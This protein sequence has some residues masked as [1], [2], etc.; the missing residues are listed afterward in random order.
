HLLRGDAL[1]Q[2]ERW[3]A[4]RAPHLHLAASTERFLKASRALKDTA[5]LHARRTIL[6]APCY[7]VAI[8]LILQLL[9]LIPSVSRFRLTHL[10]NSADLA[11]IAS[12]AIL[13]NQSGRIDPELEQELLRHAGAETVVIRRNDAQ[14]IVLSGTL[15]SPVSAT[16]DLRDPSAITLIADALSVLLRREE[17]LIRV[18]ASPQLEG[19]VITEL[20]VR[21]S[22]L[23]EAMWRYSTNIFILSFIVSLPPALVVTLLIR[24]RQARTPGG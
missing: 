11:Q 1:A 5:R 18:I 10:E 22:R 19:G 17:R 20:V 16:F 8:L 7:V 4:E 6:L 21:E 24:R 23:R 15:A 9:I 12:F 2:A 13:A 3:Q 14:K